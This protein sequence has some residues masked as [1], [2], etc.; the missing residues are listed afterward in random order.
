MVGLITQTQLGCSTGTGHRDTE[1]F[2]CE[3]IL[4][5]VTI[6][7]SLPHDYH[8]RK[9][10]HRVEAQVFLPVDDAS[11]TEA[12]CKGDSGRNP[13]ILLVDAEGDNQTNL[14]IS[15]SQNISEQKIFLQV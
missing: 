7:L 15:N 1:G 5:W 13:V 12:L 6:T 11:P 2:L 10:Q 3:H 4:L 8:G 14:D 9:H